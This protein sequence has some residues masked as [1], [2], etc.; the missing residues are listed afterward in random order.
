[1]AR[2]PRVEPRTVISDFA[3]PQVPAGQ[4]WAAL[5]DAAETIGQVLRPAA[6]QAARE[7]GAKSTYRDENGVL[8]VSEKSLLGGEMAAEHNAAAH[9]AYLGEFAVDLRDSLNE[10]ATANEFDP[11]G[12]KAA[13]KEYVDLTTKG[14]PV[15]LREE[16][17]LD[18]RCLRRG[19]RRCRA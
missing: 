9:A 17:R 16:V 2:T 4:G 15:G 19:D 11:G 13:A 12:F 5:A 18:P 8:R 14:A 10:L 7:E 1:M 3:T 6:L